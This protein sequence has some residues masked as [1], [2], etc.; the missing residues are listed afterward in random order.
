VVS[1]PPWN[2]RTL[3]DRRRTGSPCIK[4]QRI[5]AITAYPPCV[6]PAGSAIAQLQMCHT[7]PTTVKLQ[8]RNPSSAYPTN[9]PRPGRSNQAR[10]SRDAQIAVATFIRPDSS[11]RGIAAWFQM[12]HSWV[13]PPSGTAAKLTVKQFGVKAHH[14]KPAAFSWGP[15]VRMC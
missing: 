15:L 3:I 13:L 2:Q 4:S 10:V 8:F 5:Q 9:R 11:N 1:G 12:V 6:I 14:F 7:G